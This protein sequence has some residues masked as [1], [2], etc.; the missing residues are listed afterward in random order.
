MLDLRPR[1]ERRVFVWL[2]E[3]E[4]ASQ[5]DLVIVVFPDSTQPSD[6]LI[7]TLHVCFAFIHEEWIIGRMNGMSEEWMDNSG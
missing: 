7:S 3:N 1:S 6:P 2:L 4:Y 5:M